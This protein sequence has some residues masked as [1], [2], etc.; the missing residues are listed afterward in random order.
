M[1]TA[2]NFSTALLKAKDSKDLKTQ[3]QNCFHTEIPLNLLLIYSFCGLP[4]HMVLHK[5][6]PRNLVF[7]LDTVK[8]IWTE[9]PKT[10]KERSS[11]SQSTRTATSHRGLPTCSSPASRALSRCRTHAWHPESLPCVAPHEEGKKQKVGPGISG[12]GS[13]WWGELDKPCQDGHCPASRTAAAQTGAG[14]R[15]P[16]PTTSG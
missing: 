5:Y 16:R 6:I 11:T 9:V 15:A 14:Q 4:S 3:R 12:P 7:P 10:G 13:I 2:L 1:E 8:E